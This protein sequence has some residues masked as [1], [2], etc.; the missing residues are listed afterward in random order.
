MFKPLADP[1]PVAVGER[2]VAGGYLEMSGVQPTT[3]MIE[4]IEASRAVEANL[5]MMQTQDEMLSGL[6]NRLLRSA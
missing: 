5:N 3:E 4:L 1:L 2:S 6:V